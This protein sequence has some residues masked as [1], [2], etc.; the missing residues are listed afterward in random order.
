MNT[1]DK[2]DKSN[3]ACPAYD[4]CR[5]LG[6][7]MSDC[8][9]ISKLMKP[10]LQLKH[11]KPDLHGIEQFG[12]VGVETPDSV[13]EAYQETLEDYEENTFSHEAIEARRVYMKLEHVQCC[14][15]SIVLLLARKST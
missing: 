9:D 1:K 11:S 7:V 13:R 10:F 6:T 15:S 12:D 3:F 4:I 14:L 5:E 2:S 8:E